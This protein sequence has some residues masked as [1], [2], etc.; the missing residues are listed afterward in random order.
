MTART[1]QVPTQDELAA[2]AGLDDA[3]FWRTVADYG[4]VRPAAIDLDQAWFWTRSWVTKEIEADL[5]EAE[6]RIVHQSS[7]EEFLAM[8][9]RA[10]HDD[11]YLAALR[12]QA[13]H[14]ADA[15]RG[16]TVP[17]RPGSIDPS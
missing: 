16:R 7:D 14:N 17:G 5:D 11:D 13:A 3:T 1:H 9:E 12:E 15:L 4:Y 6:G 2:L 10:A 8:L